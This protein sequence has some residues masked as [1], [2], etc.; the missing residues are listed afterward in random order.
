MSISAAVTTAAG[1]VL[2]LVDKVPNDKDVKAGWLA[3]AVFVGLGLAV[4][5]LG[6]SLVKHLRRAEQNLAPK[7]DQAEDSADGSTDRS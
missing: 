3:F 2:P 5:F 7:M 4:V 1:L 6:F